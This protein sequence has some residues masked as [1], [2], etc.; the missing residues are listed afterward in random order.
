MNSDLE[1]WCVTTPAA[2]SRR[3]VVAAQHTLAAR[4]GA[5]MLDAGGNAVDAAVATAFALNAVEPWMC[6][7]GG[8]GFMVAWLAGQRRA[9]A[10]DF[11]G[12]L[13]GATDLADYPVDLDLPTTPMGFPTVVD[14]A[15]VEGYKSITVPGAVA[16]LSH[17]LSRFGTRRMAEALDPAIRIAE[18]GIDVDWFTMLQIALCARVLAR[19]P[20]SAAIYLP[21]GHPRMAE[22]RLTIPRLAETLREIAAG[23]VDCFYRG[24]LAE[25]IVADLQAGGSRITAAD[26]AAYEVLEYDPMHAEH[27][28]YSI[29]TPGESSGG[30]RQR[31][32]LAHVAGAM[33]AP[34][35]APTP[36][37]W[38]LWAEALD[39]C[40]KAHKIRNGVLTEQGACT[41]SMSAVDADGNMVALTYTLL[42]RFGSGVTLPSTGMLMN[43]GVSYFDPRPGYPT[44][45]AGGKRIN[46]SN[47]CPT[48]GVRD[49]QAL[50]AVGASGGNLIM[51][52]VS[53][54]VAL[55]TD[56]GMS[57][58]EAVHH[59]RIDASDRG[60]VRA[61]P[62]LG[63]AVIA[64]LE[65][66]SPVEVAQLLVYP[67]LYAC[68]SAVSRDPRTGECA[69]LNDPSQ[70]IGGGVTA[71]PF[72]LEDLEDRMP[73]VRA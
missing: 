19:D 13:A 39:A 23:G 60:S 55:M 56:F 42:N 31:D 62:R 2:R 43:D 21:D 54:V 61:D 30:L 24:A 25:R 66:R 1:N 4:A 32:F 58:E 68:I 20:V 14:R 65:D 17:A 44:T 8:S 33:P 71:Q 50:F 73:E 11:Q 34:P 35:A 47:I 57:V 40:W 9:V 29:Y 7:L 41:S 36:E 38:V 70:P 6:G 52:A 12:V 49:G 45:M 22:T 48:V 59:P 16:G 10:L 51:P 63:E 37:T 72:E 18:R 69:G 26:F 15:N 67:K 5:A 64:A 3:G 28:G 27:R 46:S 53:Q